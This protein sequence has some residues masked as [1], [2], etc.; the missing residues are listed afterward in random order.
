MFYHGSIMFW[1]VCVCVICILYK[2][3]PFNFSMTQS[4]HLLKQRLYNFSACL[5]VI[6]TLI[7]AL[8]SHHCVPS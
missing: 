7:I 6:V 8:S 3:A 1:G 5:S 4:F 2:C